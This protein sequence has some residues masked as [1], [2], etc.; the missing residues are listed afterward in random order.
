MAAAAGVRGRTEDSR[1]GDPPLAVV[2]HSCEEDEDA[3]C[4]DE[5]KIAPA[6]VALSVDEIL[7]DDRMPGKL[8][9]AKISDEEERP[10]AIELSVT[11]GGSPSQS[12]TAA[13]PLA[14]GIRCIWRLWLALVAVSILEMLLLAG[15]TLLDQFWSPCRQSLQ[16]CRSLHSA[17]C[18]GASCPDAAPLWAPLWPAA[19][20]VVLAAPLFLVLSGRGGSHQQTCSIALV[21]ALAAVGMGAAVL[22]KFSSTGLEYVSRCPMPRSQGRCSADMCPAPP[23]RREND[24]SPCVCGLVGEAEMARALFLSNFPACQPYEWYAAQMNTLEELVLGYESFACVIGPLTCVSMVVGGFVLLL[25]LVCCPLLFLGSCGLDRTLLVLFASDEEL[26]R[27]VEAEAPDPSAGG[28]QPVKPAS[29][30]AQLA[31]SWK[32]KTMRVR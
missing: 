21:L 11:E 1:A 28:S 24:F 13:L 29:P 3:C 15:A 22:A 18:S 25:Q 16:T 27:L 12:E 14:R 8:G 17:A 30:K 5:L 31:S 6:D 32:T 2:I 19:G 7:R 9:A 4:N 23:C 10:F 20:L 26:D